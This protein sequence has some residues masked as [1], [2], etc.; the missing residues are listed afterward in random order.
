MSYVRTYVYTYVGR[1]RWKSSNR[2]L[3][4]S[5]GLPLLTGLRTYPSRVLR[6]PS[7]RHSST[8][9]FRPACRRTMDPQHT[10]QIM[11]YGLDRRSSRQLRHNPPKCITATQLYCEQSFPRPSVVVTCGHLSAVI[12]RHW[13]V[14][15]GPTVGPVYRVLTSPSGVCTS[16]T[17]S[18]RATY[19]SCNQVH[20]SER[21]REKERERVGMIFG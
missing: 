3:K 6:L 13:I 20:N 14:P 16:R 4:P 2:W 7:L 8:A 17:R 11:L 18:V 19:P 9:L 5:G 1:L 15:V 12:I 10:E 21:E